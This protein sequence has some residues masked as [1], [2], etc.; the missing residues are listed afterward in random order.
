MPLLSVVFAVVSIE[1]GILLAL[2]L[3][4]SPAGVEGHDG[5]PGS[6]RERLMRAAGNARRHRAGGR[7]VGSAGSGSGQ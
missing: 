6:S 1:S 3:V 2:S 5:P 4:A 7:S